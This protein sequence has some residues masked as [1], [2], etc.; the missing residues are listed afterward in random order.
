MSYS[1]EFSRFNG[2]PNW[3]W[4]GLAAAFLGSMGLTACG[5]PTPETSAESVPTATESTPTEVFPASPDS[6][7]PRVWE[8]DKGKVSSLGT[9]ALRPNVI[10][11]YELI[12]HAR[13]DSCEA[14]ITITK[15]GEQ[16]YSK[17]VIV[18]IGYP[19]DH[20]VE[21]VSITVSEDPVPADCGI[22]D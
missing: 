13:G 22:K 11:D 21:N 16:I 8:F 6:D 18:A 7:V 10:V 4:V 17:T 20:K 14:L 1:P 3:Q 5:Q 19:I 15:G 2:W 12:G 9:T